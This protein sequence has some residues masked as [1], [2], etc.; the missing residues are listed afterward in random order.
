LFQSHLNAHMKSAHGV[1]RE[2]EEGEGGL[3][4]KAKGM[5]Q[6]NSTKK[7]KSVKK[8]RSKESEEDDIEDTSEEEESEL[9]LSN[10]NN[11]NNDTTGEFRGILGFLQ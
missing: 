1:G 9:N 5:G 10:N 7:R 8:R 4:P 2:E 6:R 11:H 3:T